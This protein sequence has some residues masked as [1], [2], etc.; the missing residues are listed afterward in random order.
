[1]T[2]G[3]ND[4][5]DV[6]TTIGKNLQ[7]ARED[8]KLSRKELAKQLNRFE[9][10]PVINEKQ[11]EMTEERLKKWEYGENT[12]NIEWIPFLCRALDC[13]VGYLFGDY[14]EKKREI[15]DV[16]AVTGL[17]IAAAKAIIENEYGFKGNRIESLNFLLTSINFGNALEELP[18]FRRKVKEL[19]Q[20]E[21]IKSKQIKQ[22]G[23]N[24]HPNKLLLNAIPQAIQDADLSE[25]NLSRHFGHIV[26]EIRRK[27]KEEAE[28]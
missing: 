7:G 22:Q 11:E 18:K 14:E 28:K 8:K 24:Y 12:I 26:D 23:E 15:S 1:M 19:Y 17:S 10:R 5:K 16:C 4:T 27:A 9:D 20:L 13:D 21:M 25:Y 6:K 2:G 3:R